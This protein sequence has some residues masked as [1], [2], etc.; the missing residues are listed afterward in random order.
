MFLTLAGGEGGAPGVGAHTHH[1]RLSHQ[2]VAF[3]TLELHSAPGVQ[4]VFQHFTVKHLLQAVATSAL[5]PH[6]EKLL[7]K[8]RISFAQTCD[9]FTAHLR[10]SVSAGSMCHRPDR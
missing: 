10:R 1:Q 3:I 8:R 5:C 4:V 7:I 6:T 2:P 9:R